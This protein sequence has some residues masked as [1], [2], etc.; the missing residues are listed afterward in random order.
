MLFVKQFIKISWN[1]HQLIIYIINFSPQS[2]DEQ[3]LIYSGQLLND[4]IVLKDV[5]RQYE[6]QQEEGYHQTH[7]V[8]L[9]Y[10]PKMNPQNTSSYSNSNRQNNTSNRT[11]N[12][13][14]TQTTSS[15]SSNTINSTNSDGLRQ[16]NVATNQSVP[17][18]GTTVNGGMT[19][20][21]LNY[22]VSGN[23]MGNVPNLFDFQ[24]QIN[25]NLAAQQHAMQT[26]MQ[27]AYSQYLNQYMSL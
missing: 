10:T 17:V 15:S 14:V 18:S 26:W 5:L 9:V 21:T 2:T 16:R 3:K 24:Q 25:T 27:N 11:L 20:T 13:P 6:E 12:N 23:S 19:T 7:T 4:T 8:H 1:Y 22:G